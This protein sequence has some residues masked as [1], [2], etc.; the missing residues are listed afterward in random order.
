MTQSNNLNDN[1]NDNI[2]LDK[3]YKEYKNKNSKKDGFF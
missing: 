1:N 2:D 3:Y